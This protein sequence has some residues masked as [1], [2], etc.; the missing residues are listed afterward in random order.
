MVSLVVAE[1][2]GIGINKLDYPAN[3]LCR[4]TSATFDRPSVP[5]GGVAKSPISTR[6]SPLAL[7]VYH[8]CLS[9]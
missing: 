6:F 8:A 4:C 7:S 9:L 2:E 1:P 5:N 3:Y